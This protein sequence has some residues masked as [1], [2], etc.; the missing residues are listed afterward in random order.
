MLQCH[1][2]AATHH[3]GQEVPDVEVRLRGKILGWNELRGAWVV[4]GALRVVE[5]RM[6]GCREEQRGVRRGLGRIKVF[7]TTQR[8]VTY[9]WKRG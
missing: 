1:N 6:G 8:G 5:W 4:A 7:E 3:V 2:R 9:R